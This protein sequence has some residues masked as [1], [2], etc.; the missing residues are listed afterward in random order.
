MGRHTFFISCAR[1]LRYCKVRTN[2]GPSS[3]K[4]QRMTHREQ[5]I[6]GVTKTIF[7]N[8]ISWNQLVQTHRSLRSV[9]SRNRRPGFAKSHAKCVANFAACVNTSRTTFSTPAL[10]PM[11]DEQKKTCSVTHL[12]ALTLCRGTVPTCRRVA[13]SPNSFFSPF[14]VCIPVRSNVNNGSE[15]ASLNFVMAS[16]AF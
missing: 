10:N 6:D 3:F 7:Y 11:A 4:G 16:A 14:N 15:C 8:S 5:T 1:I 12:T 9:Y 13:R 2:K